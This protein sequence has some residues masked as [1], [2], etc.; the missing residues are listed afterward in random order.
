MYYEGRWERAYFEK[1]SKFRE[2]S[3]WH[4]DLVALVGPTLAAI[5]S[6]ALW[7]WIAY[8]IR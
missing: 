2:P 7:M 1:P 5:I 6:L 3:L 8:L 4:L